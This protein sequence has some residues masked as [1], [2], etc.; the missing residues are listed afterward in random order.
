VHFLRYEKL[1]HYGLD[2]GK[3]IAPLPMPGL[4]S[5]EKALTGVLYVLV[6]VYKGT[7]VVGMG[8]FSLPRGILLLLGEEAASRSITHKLY[9]MSWTPHN[10]SLLFF[11]GFGIK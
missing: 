11:R 8:R 6:G 10:I 7:G 3:K 1:P 9:S 2:G 4:S 5:F